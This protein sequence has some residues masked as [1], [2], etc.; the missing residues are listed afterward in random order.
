LRRWADELNKAGNNAFPGNG[1]P[2]DQELARLKRELQQVKQERDFLIEA[3]AFA[4]TSK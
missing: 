3:A 2:R 1:T 4:K